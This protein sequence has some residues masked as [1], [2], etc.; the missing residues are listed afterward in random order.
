MRPHSIISLR[1]DLLFA[2]PTRLLQVAELLTAI[3][4]NQ[5]LGQCKQIALDDLVEIIKG[6]TD[7]MVGHPVLREIVSAHFLRSVARSNQVAASLVTV[8]A[9]IF[10][11]L[12]EKPA[13][14]DPHGL[15]FVFVLASLVA[16]VDNES[17]GKVGDPHPALRFV[18]VLPPRPSRPHDVNLEVLGPNDVI[19]V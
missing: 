17:R 19:D 10:L 7:S 1:V 3:V 9:R 5:R 16:A 6:Q 14:K 15:R 11:N 18:L 4:V 12:V 2:S 8:R 13:T